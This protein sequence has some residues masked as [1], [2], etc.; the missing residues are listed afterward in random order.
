MYQS[1]IM[2]LAKSRDSGAANRAESFLREAAL[3]YP[4]KS[5]SVPGTTLTTAASGTDY[6]A[7]NAGIDIATCNAVLTAWAKSSVEYGPERAEKLIFWMDEVDR[8]NGNHGFVR[9]SM[10]S[11]TSLIDAY[12]QKLDWESVCQ[13]ERLFN[14]LLDQYLNDDRSIEDEGNVADTNLLEPNIA[15]WTIVIS[16]WSKLARKG[17]KGAPKRADRLM[18]RMQEL[19]RESRISFGPDAIVC[20]SVM[21]AWAS[22]READGP[23]RA[24]E[25]LQEMYEQYLDGNDSMKPS[26]RAIGIVLESWMKSNLPDAMDRAESLLDAY[27]EYLMLLC[28]TGQED[29]IAVPEEVSDIYRTMLYG[30]CKNGD[31]ERALDYLLDMVD[32]NMKIDSFCFDRVIE[33]NTQLN[34]EGSF[35]R[36]EKVFDLL[37]ECRIK[38]LVKPNERVYTSYIRALIKA[39][40]PNMAEKAYSLLKR[41]KDLARKGDNQGIQPEVFTYNAVLMACAETSQEVDS[42]SMNAFK[43]A[44]KVFNELRSQPANGGSGPDH[45]S[46]GNMLRC[47]KLLTDEAQRISLINSTFQ[48]CCQQGYV[49]VFVLRD[50]QLSAP[51]DV[52]RQMLQCPPGMEVDL[53]RFPASWSRNVPSK[54]TTKQSETSRRFR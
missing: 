37:E 22:L 6:H 52:W 27:E 12:A 18:Q 21:N 19:H 10:S 2:T 11:F 26:P 50:L 3:R 35:A 48:L 42:N 17:Y 29:T 8:N 24:Q 1:L 14:R 43:I 5:V 45:V 7:Q 49:N 13:A 16:A 33:A 15:T 4:P 25:V 47:S 44:I 40:V 20:N 39:R 54:K 36:S 53:E 41:M 51:E 34:L 9:P 28:G 31:P 46:F 30:W 38:G 32:Q 23:P